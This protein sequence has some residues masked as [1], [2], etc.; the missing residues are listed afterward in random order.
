MGRRSTTPRR[1]RRHRARLVTTV[2]VGATALGETASAAFIR[3]RAA[4]SVH[5][6]R[7]ESHARV[8]R[9]VKA[10]AVAHR[11]L[12]R[13]PVRDASPVDGQLNAVVVDAGANLV[14]VPAPEVQV[15]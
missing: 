3:F 8:A 10:L 4:S 12:L 2:P 1:M 14:G 7:V 6:E 11:Y 5:V 9:H 13:L 15:R